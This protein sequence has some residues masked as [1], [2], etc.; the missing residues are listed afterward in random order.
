MDLPNPPDRSANVTATPV[1]TPAPPE[2]APL[3]AR[4]WLAQNGVMMLL[5]IAAGGFLFNRVGFEGLVPAALAAVGLGFLIFIHEL[6]HFAAAKWCDV[7]VKTFSIGFGPAIPGM[8][9]TLGETLYMIGILPLGGYVNMVGE[10]TENDEDE[11]NPRSFKA[12][13]VLQRM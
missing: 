2:D 3:T 9:F 8:H 7:H 6:G 11:L 10:G 12:K 5:L 13:G 1:P 4:G